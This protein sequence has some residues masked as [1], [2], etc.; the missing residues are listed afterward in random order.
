MENQQPAAPL[1]VLTGGNDR[2]VG[3]IRGI[4]G[5]DSHERWHFEME[6]DD[7]VPLTALAADSGLVYAATS[8]G[9]VYGLRASDSDL[10]WQHRVTGR[11]LYHRYPEWRASGG[12]WRD[13]GRQ[14]C[15][16]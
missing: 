12:G 3:I 13:Y 14:L 10:V 4:D 5:H 6:R 8:D 15:A 9:L 7:S 16:L 2:H 11:H 1:V